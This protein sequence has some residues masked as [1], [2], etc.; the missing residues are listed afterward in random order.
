VLDGLPCYLL[1]AFAALIC[2]SSPATASASDSQEL[3]KAKTF[4]ENG[5]CAHARD[6][7][8]ALLRNPPTDVEELRQARTYLAASY[9]LLGDE[10]SARQQFETLFRANPFARVDSVLFPP[11]VVDLADSVLKKLEKEAQAKKDDK[12]A[13]ANDVNANANGSGATNKSQDGLAQN[14]TGSSASG[15]ANSKGGTSVIKNN[16]PPIREP[17]PLAYAFV[18]FGVGQFANDQYGKGALFLTAETILVVSFVANAAFA[19]SLKTGGTPF[20]SYQVA[21]QNQDAFNRYQAFYIASFWIGVG[22]YAI[23]VIDALIS[24]PTVAELNNPNG[25]VG[26]MGSRASLDSAM[27]SRKQFQLLPNGL[28]VRF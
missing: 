12:G 3:A 11:E 14:T 9:L 24:R 20:I 19:E 5:D 23:E 16:P 21:P 10:A 25:D 4:Y 15:N 27:F 18:P 13:Q 22:V 6:T 1:V 26:G 2:A 7:L 17:P 28:Q 8:V